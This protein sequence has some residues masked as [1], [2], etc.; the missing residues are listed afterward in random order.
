V[1]PIILVTLIIIFIFLVSKK[2]KLNEQKTTEINLEI[3]NINEKEM[4]D[5]ISQNIPPKIEIT[6]TTT[7]SINN[8]FD[9]SIIDVTNQSEIIE[10]NLKLIKYIDGVPHWAH[11][12]VYSFSEIESATTEQK[13]FYSIFKSN[14]LNGIY[15]DLEGNTNYSFIL[16]F[17]LLNDYDTH[18]NINKLESE[19]KIL[20]QCYPKT[21]SYCISFL[22]KKMELDGYSENISKLREEENINYQTYYSNYENDDWKLGNRYKSKLKLKDEEIKLLNKLWNPTNNF[23]SID[24]CCKEIIKLFISIISKLKTIY[25]S[26]NT[27]IDNEFLFVADVIARKEFKFKKGSQNYK[28]SIESITNEFYTNIFKLCENAVREYY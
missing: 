5:E 4:K 26:E 7:S 25:E 13:K 27:S 14:F 16:L 8:K 28:Y 20:G 22:I 10:S 9:D 24:F 17:D 12:Y 1:I 15:F 19:L 23:C 3:K 21:K 18:K 6:I 11:H 2:K